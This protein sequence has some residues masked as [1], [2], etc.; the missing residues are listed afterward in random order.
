M[1]QRHL[2]IFMAILFL[3]SSTYLF[4]VSYNFSAN[5]NWWAV[6]FSHPQDVSWNFEIENHTDNTDFHYEIFDGKNKI[7]EN[8]IIV[9]NGDIRKLNISSDV[10]HI[11]NGKITIIV[12]DGEDKKEIYKN[13]DK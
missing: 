9:K 7:N 6:Y 10:G 12:T 5:K 1:R 3:T 4:F 11:E 2:I 13:F 8:D